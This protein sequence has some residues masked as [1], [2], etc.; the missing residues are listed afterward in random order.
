MGTPGELGDK[1]INE[2]SSDRIVGC[3]IESPSAKLFNGVLLRS[4]NRITEFSS[5]QGIRYVVLPNMDFFN[6]I[7]R[8]LGDVEIERR[9]VEPPSPGLI[10]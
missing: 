4:R 5:D 1:R 6:E 9:H 8:N 2:I 7:L 10:K 3:K